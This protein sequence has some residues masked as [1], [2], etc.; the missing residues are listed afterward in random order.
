MISLFG[1]PE[2][3]EGIRSAFWGT[4]GTNRSCGAIIPE[5]KK[6]A[7]CYALCWGVIDWHN[8]GTVLGALEFGLGDWF[9]YL[10]HPVTF[11]HGN[12]AP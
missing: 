2:F 11:I 12:G 8:C 4:D 10:T 5:V 1:E 3:V 7:N 9:V 6:G